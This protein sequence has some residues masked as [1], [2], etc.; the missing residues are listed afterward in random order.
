MP[1]PAQ[2]L[3][4]SSPISNHRAAWAA[5]PIVGMTILCLATLRVAR[6]ALVTR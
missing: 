6:I 1:P 5:E 4:P 3:L 2:K